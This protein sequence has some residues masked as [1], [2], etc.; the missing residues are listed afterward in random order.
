MGKDSKIGSVSAEWLHRR[1]GLQLVHIQWASQTLL[2]DARGSLAEAFCQ[3]SLCSCWFFPINFTSAVQMSY[4][5]NDLR[6][7]RSPSAGGARRVP[8]FL[9]RSGNLHRLLHCSQRAGS[10]RALWSSPGKAPGKWWKCLPEEKTGSPPAQ[11]KMT[12][13]PGRWTEGLVLTECGVRRMSTRLSLCRRGNNRDSFDMNAVF[14]YNP[15]NPEE[16]GTTG[17]RWRCSGRHE[18]PAPFRS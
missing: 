7:R 9:L 11:E 15:C 12:S 1:N 18:K 2:R 5:R 16:H 6:P 14:L 10:S 13:S 17:S 3:S 8:L 4:M